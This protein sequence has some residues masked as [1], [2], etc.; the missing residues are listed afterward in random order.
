MG[1]YILLLAFCI[2]FFIT[3]SACSLSSGGTKTQTETTAI[4]PGPQSISLVNGEIS[5]DAETNY[6][7]PFIVDTNMKE[8]TVEGTF[9]TVD[10]RP[11]IQVYIMDDATYTNWLKGRNIPIPYDSGKRSVGFI[12][13]SLAAPGKYQLIFTNWIE[14]SFS[15]SQKVSARVDLKWTY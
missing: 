12:N 9:R 11:N 1:K 8:V 13:K 14:A 6:A 15:P 10:G 7:I 3:F 2:T 5:V 4:T